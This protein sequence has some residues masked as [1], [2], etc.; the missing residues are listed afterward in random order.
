MA[1]DIGPKIGIEGEAEYR[2][3]INDINMTMRTLGTE[4]KAVS[5]E[6][7][8]NEK[9]IEAYTAKN[10]VLSKEIEEQQKKLA[11]LQQMLQKS[12]EKY[13][14][15]DS[16]TQRWQQAVNNAT[17]DLNK[18]QAELEQNTRAMEELADETDDTRDSLE[19]GG[20]AAQSF[21]DMLKANLSAEALKAGAEKISDAVNGIANAM[22]SYSKESETAT[23][24]ATAYFGE[25][26]EAA[27]ETA[28]VIKDVFTDGIGDSME[29]VADN[30]I[31]V[32]QNLEG[33]SQTDL[34]NITEQVTQMDELFGI[35][36]SESVRGVN[37]LM[38]NFGVDA[39]TAMD[40]IVTGTQN[41]LDKTNELGDNISEYSAKF[42]EAGYS[43]DEYFQLLQN[44]LQN[45]AYNLDKVN[46]AINEVTTRLSDGTIA[47]AIGQYSAKTQQY[48]KD[49]QNGKRTQ[50]DVIESIVADINN[51]K[52][53]QEQFNLASTAFGT[54]AEDGGLKAVEALTSVGN[55][56]TDISGKA[57]QFMEDSMTSQQKLDAAMRTLQDAFSPIS[58][59]L[60]NA[61]TTI[62]E[63]VTPIIEKIGEVIG[64]LSPTLQTII[65]IIAA[66]AVAI[67]PVV[68]V[69]GTVISAIT[70]IIGVV[71]PVIT[72]LGSLG[73]V[74]GSLV[75]LINPVTMVIGS[76][77]AGFIVAYNTSEKF[78][79]VVNAAFNAV[80]EVVSGVLEFIIAILTG[81]SDKAGEIINSAMNKIS[82]IINK[83]LTAIKDWFSEKFNAIKETV[84]NVM[85]GV[86]DTI[87]NVMNTVK[88]I[89]NNAWDTVSNKIKNVIPSIKEAVESIKTAVK[90]KFDEMVQSAKDW[91]RNLIQG[92]A[93]GIRSAVGKVTG[94]V[95]GVMSS[96]KDF[97]GFN[98]P[99]KKGDGR[100]IVDWGQNMVSGFL[101]GVK[102][103]MSDVSDT[104]GT[105]TSTM[106]ASLGT[107]QAAARGTNSVNITVNVGSVRNDNDIKAISQGLNRTI[108]NYSRALG[109]VN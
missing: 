107:P 27:E 17:A 93:D 77:V 96:I 9:S 24:K 19:E 33:L 1:Y 37:A 53:Q 106:A 101:D 40:Y 34:T 26:G 44:G 89:W 67:G 73:A 68:V 45:G 46:D 76:L 80:K 48:F 10:E 42:S 16:K 102:A 18:M 74:F 41:G 95:K 104:A 32:K 82:D 28:S 55:S 49:W 88:D 35:D 100:F 85:N 11:L 8:G 66:V 7:I 21:G 109:V 91:G 25:T 51:A 94:A 58:D 54:I 97:I 78:R 2:K 103:A 36:V 3:Q 59:A 99:S 81:D 50:K 83:V 87:N 52:S 72:A 62:A 108:R 23:T 60:L 43:A 38:Q 79:D 13:G 30:L 6:F 92:F 64:N 22:M 71:T 12:A 57:Q 84:L 56:Y 69:L 105:L 98:S 15:S 86:K 20:D 90:E 5:S 39:Q 14:E 61:M 63:A 47:D 65:A 75:A 4:M 29:T 70:T 31:T